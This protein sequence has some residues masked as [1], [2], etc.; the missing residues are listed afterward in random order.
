MHDYSD[1]AALDDGR[2]SSF[3]TQGPSDIPE[4][5]GQNEARFIDEEQDDDAPLSPAPRLTRSRKPTLKLPDAAD[6]TDDWHAR[7]FVDLFGE[8]LVYCKAW[9][10][11]L[12]YDGHCWRKDSTLIAQRR[13][14]ESVQMLRQHIS[15]TSNE[16]RRREHDDYM[17]AVRRAESLRAITATVKLAQTDERIA[18]KPEDFDTDHFMLNCLNGTID[19]RTGELRPHDPDDRLTKLAPARF[20]PEAPCPTWDAFLH[21][22]MGGDEEMIGYIRRAAGYA[23]TGDVGEQCLFLLYGSGQNGKTVLLNALLH[24]LGD[25]GMTAPNHLLTSAG[26]QQHPSALA[27]L[28][29]MRLVALSEPNESRFDEALVKWL[30]GGDAIRAHKMHCDSY[31]FDPTHKFF[32]LANHKPDIQGG[33]TAIWRRMRLIVFAITIPVQEKDK[34]LEDKLKLESSGILGW[35]VRGCREW[36]EKGSLKEPE[37]IRQSTTAYRDEMDP[38]AGFLTEC[39]DRHPGLRV[40]TVKL[41]TAYQRWCDRQGTP[42]SERVRNAKKFGELL[43]QK[44]ICRTKQSSMVYLD[45]D[46]KPPVDEYVPERGFDAS[47]DVEEM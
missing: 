20:F 11:W 14:R 42:Q 38:I 27:D 1:E 40:G 22:I 28:D 39:C 37:T 36:Q 44:R 46:L 17:A 24:V 19:L 29:G 45:I 9:N 4:P 30:T 32:M 43:A 25:Y 31:E 13:A 2:L 35:M 41:W 18:V 21:R 5:A 6:M 16:H 10:C 7:R 8:R 26:R 3:E 15:E 33:G 34:N 47:T 12:A 23:L